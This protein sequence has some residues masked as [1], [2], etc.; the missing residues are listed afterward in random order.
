MLPG[1]TWHKG[2]DLIAVERVVTGSPPFPDPA[3]LREDEQLEAVRRFQGPA[4]VLADRLG[5]A[6]RTITR[7][8]T[9]VGW[10]AADERL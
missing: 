8:R 1:A 2:I 5:I 7:L 3:S 4:H 10:E 9:D 6:E